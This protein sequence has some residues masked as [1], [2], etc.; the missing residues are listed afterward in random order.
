MGA[1]FIA[2]LPGKGSFHSSPKMGVSLLGV[3]S[4]RFAVVKGG[5]RYDAYLV[6]G[7]IWDAVERGPYPER[8]EALADAARP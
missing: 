8:L 7:D 2:G 1:N 4:S 5:L 3:S 6:W